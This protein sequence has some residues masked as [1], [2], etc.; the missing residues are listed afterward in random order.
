M[1]IS[2]L[3]IVLFFNIQFL[4]IT[5]QSYVHPSQTNSDITNSYANTGQYL[6]IQV[7]QN[8]YDKDPILLNTSSSVIEILTPES[9]YLRKMANLT[10]SD[11]QAYNQT[12]KIEEDIGFSISPVWGF[13]EMA[14]AFTIPA[15]SYIWKFE[16]QHDIEDNGGTLQFFV[17]NATWDNG[18]A[19]PTVNP[20]ARTLLTQKT[21]GSTNLNAEYYPYY[22]TGNVQL[23]AS[24]TDNNTYFLIMNCTGGIFNWFR[25]DSSSDPSGVNETYGYSSSSWGSWNFIPD[26]N[27]DSSDFKF[28][29]YLAPLSTSPNPEDS[30]LNMTVNGTSVSNWAEGEYDGQWTSNEEIPCG[31]SGVMEY[32]FNVDWPNAT[33]YVNTT[34]ISYFMKDQKECNFLIES[35]GSDVIWSLS[36]NP[37]NINYLFSNITISFWIPQVWTEILIQNSSNYVDYEILNDPLK[38]DFK[39]ICINASNNDFFVFGN[40]KNLGIEMK[41]LLDNEVITKIYSNDEIVI[42]CLLRKVIMYE[43]GIKIISQTDEVIDE[44][45]FEGSNGYEIK[46]IWIPKKSIPEKYGLFTICVF[47]SNGIN[48]SLYL[49]G[50]L[51]ILSE[52]DPNDSNLNELIYF[53]LFGSISVIF[54]FFYHSKKKKRKT[55]IKDN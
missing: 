38:P 24:Q 5:G 43:I 51:D 32:E 34:E 16:V 27:G 40:T 14:A 28:N 12:L 31:S 21:Y 15:D 29:I 48:E 17:S 19:R 54:I 37:N 13:E 1:K 2:L 22:P 41:F 44:I 26:T 11:I 36:Y 52:N 3:I 23:N 42:H 9:T 4:L 47:S 49:K 20:A 39:I 10:V 33:W 45:L 18:Y 8:F 50:V 53:I 55:Q 25:L 46:Q 35:S 7:S 6:D 30:W